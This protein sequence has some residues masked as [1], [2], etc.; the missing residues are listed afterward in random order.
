MAN[1]IYQS[2]PILHLADIIKKQHTRKR[3]SCVMFGNFGACNLGD[4]AIL[5][6]ELSELTK[7]SHLKTTVVAK[8]PEEVKRLHN[9]KAISFYAFNTL[10]K[11]LKKAD[12]LI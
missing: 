5:A 4:E 3:L 6:G 9:T 8:F 2:L 7:I 12:F 1:D 10:R 11:E